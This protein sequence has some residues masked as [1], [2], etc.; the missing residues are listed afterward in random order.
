MVSQVR[1]SRSFLEIPERFNMAAWAVDRHVAEGR[2][3]KIAAWASDRSYTFDEIRQLSNRFG[4]VLLDRGVRRGDCVM[5]RLGA[6]A[7]TMVAFLGVLKIGAVALPTNRLF[8]EYE[9]EKILINSEAVAVI[10]TPELIGPVEAVRARCPSLKHVILFGAVGEEAGERLMERASAELIVAST[11]RDELAVII[12]TSG[13]TGEPKGVE[14]GHRWVIGTGDPITQAMARLSADDICYQPQDWSFNY[15]LG[16]GFLYPFHVGA[17]IVIPEGRFNA[18]AAFA[19]IERHHVT[20]FAAVPTIYRMMLAVPDA[21]SR[22]RLDSLRLGLSAGEPLPAPTY[23]EWKERL[24][25]T[26]LD[27]IGQSEC[28][29]FVANQLG[30]EIRPGSMGKPLPSY[31]VAVLD[32][33]G[34]P[35]PRGEPGHLVFRND[36]PG[37]TLGYHR[38]AERWAAVNRDGWYYTKDIAYVDD[39]GYYW[40][41]SRSD[42]LIKSRAYLISPKEVESALLDHP[43]VLEAGIVGVPDPVM[44]HKVKAYLTL[45]PGVERS[46]ELSEELRA[47]ARRLIAPY[48]VPQ[49]IEFVAELPKTLNGKILRRELRARG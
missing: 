18:E 26:I 13:T 48:K 25:L 32:D 43:A 49:E 37:L 10:S 15:P 36:H 4:N 5:L 17:P 12:Y 22:F 7:D 16:C 34:R 38:D 39:D 47:H 35:Q 31:Q 27:G 41:V 30:S 14:Y 20:V 29:I 8:R 21:E 46:A 2:G 23:R 40:Y 3:G 1:S 45:R 6:N 42:D 19:T 24:G 11:G 28:H 9:I 44:G 33:D